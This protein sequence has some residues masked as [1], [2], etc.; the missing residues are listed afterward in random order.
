[1]SD[2]PFIARFMDGR[3]AV[4]VPWESSGPN[5]PVFVKKFIEYEDKP[6][7]FSTE[8]RLFRMLPSNESTS[9]YRL[10][11][12]RDAPYA[13]IL[14]KGSMIPESEAVALL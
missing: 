7:V 14:S 10:E 12:D 13:D 1:M 4:G 5:A 9:P 2:K 6:F 8:G 3:D 11:W